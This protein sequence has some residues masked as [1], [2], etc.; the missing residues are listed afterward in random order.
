MHH[1]EIRD[2]SDLDDELGAWVAESHAIGSVRAAKP[3]KKT[4]KRKR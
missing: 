4:K 2:E 3:R 1:F